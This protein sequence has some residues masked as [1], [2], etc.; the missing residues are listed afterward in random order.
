MISIIVPVYNARPFLEATIGS[1][2]AQTYR[3][4]ELI[5]VDDGS[6]DDSI[7]YIKGI[8]DDRIKILKNDKKGVASA[9]NYGLARAQG[10]YIAFLD[11]D[12]IWDERKLEKTMAFMK[13]KDAGFVF[14][15][16]EFGDENARPTG[17]IVHVPEMMTYKKALSR[18]VIFTSTVIIDLSKVDRKFVYM[19]VIESEDTA[20]WWNILRTGIIG[21]GLDE[22]LTVYRRSGNTLSSNKLVALRRIWNLYR[23]N[24]KMNVIK[25]FICFVGWSVRAV[26]RRL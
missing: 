5:F 17:K 21:Y 9:R 24:E 20:T 3:D 6:T 16:Y 2:L 12:D 14:T 4:F 18:T 25:S 23:K 11:A 8:N 13:K 26:A 10:E 1:V 15:A 7:E 22:S 19:P